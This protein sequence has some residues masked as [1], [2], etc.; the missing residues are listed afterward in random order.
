MMMKDVAGMPLADP[1]VETLVFDAPTVV[2]E[3]E[4]L[5][6][7]GSGLW[8]LAKRLRAWHILLAKGV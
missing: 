4:I 3:I 5:Y 6:W 7:D 1:F 2:A 8:V